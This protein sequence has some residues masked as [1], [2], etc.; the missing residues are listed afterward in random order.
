MLGANIV[1]FQAQEYAHHFLQTCSHLLLVEADDY[2]LQLDDRYVNVSYCP[3][4]ITPEQIC[5]GRQDPVVIEWN[6]ILEEKYKG[7]H[8]IVATDKLESTRGIRQKLLAYEMF[9]NQNPELAKKVVMIQ[10][11]MSTTGDDLVSDD[12]FKSHLS[13]LGLVIIETTLNERL[14][15]T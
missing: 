6:Q 12:A 11:A 10:V 4:G 3:L 2:G 1:V 7:M 14:I 15:F 9:L 8:I 5:L 13:Y